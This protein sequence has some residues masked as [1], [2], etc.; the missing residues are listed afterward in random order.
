MLNWFL[1]R[2]IL[3]W[4]GVDVGMAG[5]LAGCLCLQ[6]RRTWGRGDERS[7]G[8]S[9]GAGVCARWKIH[10]QRI[11]VLDG[12]RVGDWKDVLDG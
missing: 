8:H 6:C 11:M 1:R 7:A 9:G 10:W 12:D 3:G 5:S 2:V 4:H